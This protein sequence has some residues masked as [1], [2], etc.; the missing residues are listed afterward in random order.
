MSADKRKVSTDA[1]ETLGT[2]ITESE[3]RDAIHVAVEPVKAGHNLLPGQHVGIAN[4]LAYGNVDK[5]L[6]IVDPFII[7]PILEGQYFWLLVYPRQITSLRHV[8]EHPDFSEEEE[9]EN[10]ETKEYILEE[11]Q[12]LA[13]EWIETWASDIGSSYN[14]VMNGAQIYLEQGTYTYG[15]GNEY[16]SEA[17]YDGIEEFWVQYSILT[18]KDFGNDL[19]GGFFTCAC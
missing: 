12:K 5:K 13:R 10:I 19:S 17:Q 4:G 16:T 8:W 6:G 1:L 11:K 15:E 3:K 7:G 18:G 14:E 2:I 9:K